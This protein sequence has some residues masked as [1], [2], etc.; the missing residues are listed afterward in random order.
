MTGYSV[1]RP[2]W[3][4]QRAAAASTSLPTPTNGWASPTI[5]PRRALRTAREG[6]SPPQSSTASPGPFSVSVPIS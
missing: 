1:I 3:L 5:L 6:L 4:R 2:A